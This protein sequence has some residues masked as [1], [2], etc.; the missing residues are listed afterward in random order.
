MKCLEWLAMTSCPLKG[1]ILKRVVPV[2]NLPVTAIKVLLT[3][4]KENSYSRFYHQNQIA[5]LK[6][7]YRQ[8]DDCDRTI[9]PVLCEL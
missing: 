5:P 2:A 6:L 9:Q 8:I 3:I 7:N 1:C 4:E